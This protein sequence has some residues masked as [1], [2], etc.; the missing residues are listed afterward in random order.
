MGHMPVG[1]VLRHG[2]GHHLAQPAGS[3]DLV[4]RSI[5]RGVAETVAD[6]Q[7]S[8]SDV[9]GLDHAHAGHGLGRDR[10]FQKHIVACCERGQGRFSVSIIWGGDDGHTGQAPLP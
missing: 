4:D 6:L 7:L 8:S 5:E 1:H 9:K 2:D 3:D 10:L